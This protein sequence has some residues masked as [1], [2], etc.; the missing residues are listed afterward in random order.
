M[1]SLLILVPFIFL[2][3]CDDEVPI[4]TAWPNVP[5]EIKQACPDL[6]NVKEGTTKLSEV[7]DVVVDNYAEYHECRAKV[8][9]WIE[10][11]NTQQKIHNE[12]AK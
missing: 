11:Y 1:K 12:L 3:G 2:L 7:I 6:K 5:S 4:T 9:A 8:D 10:W